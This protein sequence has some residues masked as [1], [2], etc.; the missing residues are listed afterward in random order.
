MKKIKNKLKDFFIKSDKKI[1]P[2]PEPKKKE[3]E[4]LNFASSL[5]Q[6]LG[7]TVSVFSEFYSN[8]GNN[9]RDSMM[10][11]SIDDLIKKI[12]EEKVKQ[13]LLARV[14]N[15][16]I[17]G[18]LKSDYYFSSADGDEIKEEKVK[19]RFEQI[20]SDSNLES[21]QFFREILKNLVSYSN[22][23]IVPMRDSSKAGVGELKRLLLLQ[24]NGWRTNKTIGTC[25]CEEMIFSPQNIH[26]LETSQKKFNYAKDVWHYTFNKES[27]EIFGMPLWCSVIPFLRKYNFL[28]SSSIDSYSDQSIEKT[29]YAVGVQKNGNIRA[30]SPKSYDDIMSQ[31][32]YYSEDDL[33]CDV[34]IDVQSIKKTF[35]SPDKL[36]QTLELQIIAGLHT[37]RSQLGES[38][39]G[40]QDAETQQE[41]TMDIIS[42]FQENLE[43]CVNKTIIKEICLDLFGSSIGKNSIKLKF[44]E[45][46]DIQER[47]E[48]HAAFN[49][50]AG[51]IDLDEARKNTG[52][53]SR[54]NE[55]KTFF[56]LYQQKEMSGT[57]ENVNSP[58]NQ[59]T[60][61]TGTQTTKKTKKD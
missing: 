50:Q 49:F 14:I 36:I 16:I 28:L 10:V 38:G 2:K 27:D 51:I 40:R 47:K 17:K 61:K 46:F 8:F 19:E 5:K 26:G 45:N 55:K 37:S 57:V 4:T 20:M 59:H 23:Y 11:L 13:P 34:P 52:K 33:I 42:D 58:K 21:R 22:A 6:I 53:K 30:V 25:Y 9:R 31:L 44:E 24:S 7:K 29:I 32:K 54:L 39:A 18:A 56:N 15:N 1:P 35:T 12:K 43:D 48:K 60:G 41:S 3:K